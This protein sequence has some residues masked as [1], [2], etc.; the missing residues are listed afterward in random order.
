M[1]KNIL[2]TGATDGLGK[3]LAIQL[4]KKDNYN[5]ILCG[6]NHEKMNTLIQEID[7]DKVVYYKCFDMMNDN[8]IVEF[9]DYLINNQVEIHILI[10]NVGANPQK[11]F[12]TDLNIQDCKTMMQLNCYSHLMLIKAF[13]PQMKQRKSGHIVNILSSSCLYTSEKNSA[14]T[15]SK[16][17]MEAYSKALCKEA[18]LDNIKVIGV[19]PGGIDTAFRAVSNPS[20]LK[21]HTVATAVIS[22]IELPDEANVHDLVIRPSSETNF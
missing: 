12:V 8:E 2:I 20:Y 7:S 21:P 11:N 22:C 16:K 17:S 13:Y 5:L 18:R 3:S 9:C 10:N 6:R 15:A 1:K 4:A 19:Y 14:Y